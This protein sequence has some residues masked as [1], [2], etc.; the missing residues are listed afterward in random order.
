MK[1]H[2]KLLKFNPFLIHQNVFL[3]LFSKDQFSEGEKRE[4]EDRKP[5]RL[6]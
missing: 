2:S 5:E 4:K 6:T 1:L 3:V